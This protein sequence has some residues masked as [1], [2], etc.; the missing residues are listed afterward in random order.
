MKW[1]CC[2]VVFLFY[3]HPALHQHH[4]NYSVVSA[5]IL[6]VRIVFMFRLYCIFMLFCCLCRCEVVLFTPLHGHVCIV[7]GGSLEAAVLFNQPDK[8]SEEAT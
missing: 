5:A 6:I 4:N 8:R 1:S 3:L 7:E 2:R